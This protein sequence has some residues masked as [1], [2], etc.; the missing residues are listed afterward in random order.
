MAAG[1]F[2]KYDCPM[3]ETVITII[4]DLLYQKYIK[5]RW[6][7]FSL[8]E[9]GLARS[10]WGAEKESLCV[11]G[12]NCFRILLYNSRTLAATYVLGDQLV[13]GRPNPTYMAQSKHPPIRGS[14]YEMCPG[15]IWGGRW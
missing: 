9:F 11:R 1:R 4:L 10:E 12:V 8:A 2:G 13:N 3:P 14:C 15:Q 7:E 6:W 5:Q